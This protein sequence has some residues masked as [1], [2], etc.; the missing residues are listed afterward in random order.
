MRHRPSRVKSADDARHSAAPS[1]AGTDDGGSKLSKTSRRTLRKVSKGSA[2]AA[3]AP[4]YEEDAQWE[5][6]DV[7]HM[8][9]LG[10][11]P[12]EHS[13]SGRRADSVSSSTRRRPSQDSNSSRLRIRTKHG[14]SRRSESLAKHSDPALASVVS[15][16]T[17]LSTASE[18]NTTIT[19]KSERRRKEKSVK[20]GKVKRSKRSETPSIADTDATQ[21]DVFQF[22]NED[23]G[24]PNARLDAL[25]PSSASVTSSIDSRADDRSS[26]ASEGGQ[27]TPRTSPTS[28]RRSHSHGAPYF[29][30][31]Q[32]ASGKPLYASSFV[33]GPGDEE[34]E[35]SD[36]YSEDESMY[37]DGHSQ[38]PSQ[39]APYWDYPP[40]QHPHVPQ[41]HM[42]QSPQPHHRVPHAGVLSPTVQHAVPMYDPRMYS[43]ASPT[44]TSQA[45]A[46]PPAASFPPPLAIG[47]SPESATPYP[48]QS[49][50]AMHAPLNMVQS[51]APAQA[52]AAHHMAMIPQRPV[53]HSANDTMI[54]YEL[55]AHKLSEL[56]KGSRADS[57][58]PAYRKFEQLNHRV[59]L[60][61]QD[62]ISELE[63]ELRELDK[64]IAEASPGAQ[65][66]HR[67]PAS[68]RGD[69]QFG[70]DLH[71]RRIEI[72]GQVFL[73]LEQYSKCPIAR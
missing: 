27:D 31:Y 42:L 25:H 37:D 12:E 30:Q 67:H 71:R 8:P 57:V 32:N 41:G 16:S 24:R 3:P 34:A 66:G 53:E 48:H 4:I 61:L 11:V 1:L 50:V 39:S 55:L 65:T 62:E 64:E 49:P 70:N 45:S 2:T 17:Q 51:P 22:L 73:K 7:G 58:V 28:T 35:H 47:Y 10:Q 5:D 21:S 13:T 44:S 56:K 26:D 60:H 9:N 72:L 54:G 52:V 68:R 14:S 36:S 19:E 59:L 20:G 63:E 6:D 15:G 33:H 46:W 18:S 69:T 23:A 38:N 29:T 43:G 40:N